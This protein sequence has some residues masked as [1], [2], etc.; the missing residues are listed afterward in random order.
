[1][2][3]AVLNWAD[4]PQIISSILYPVFNCAPVTSASGFTKECSSEELDTI[5][6]KACGF[7][8]QGY[9]CFVLRY[10]QIHVTGATLYNAR[11]LC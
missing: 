2:F 4:Y 3:F 11:D 5:Q 10:S 9:H 8:K 6:V 7:L 1:M